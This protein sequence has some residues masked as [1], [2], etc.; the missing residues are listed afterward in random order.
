MTAEAL[1]TR[2]LNRGSVSPCESPIVLRVADERIEG[3][4]VDRSPQGYGVTTDR[5]PAVY[6]GERLW[7]QT[8]SG[9]K[10]AKVRYVVPLGG[11]ARIGLAV[12]DLQRNEP[13]EGASSVPD[14]PPVK[15]RRVV[16]GPVREIACCVAMALALSAG[17]FLTSGKPLSNGILTWVATSQG[18]DAVADSWFINDAH[19]KAAQAWGSLIFLTPEVD[20]LLQLNPRQRVRITEIA[21]ACANHAREAGI[22]ADEVCGMQ[23]EAHTEAL[24]VLSE[25]QR[26]RWQQ[27]VRSVFDAN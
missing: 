26:E 17:A 5:H 23:A 19:R 9:W 6:E 11:G 15:Q 18:A 24:A 8:Q 7:V 13:E 3:R 2:Q 4:L 16:S 14:A 20:G 10:P 27:A 25:S 22:Q 12:E 1:D 21:A